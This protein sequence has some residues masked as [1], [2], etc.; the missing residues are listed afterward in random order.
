[1]KKIV[2]GYQ[3]S[4]DNSFEPVAVFDSLEEAENYYKNEGYV[5]KG[6]NLDFYLTLSKTDTYG[7]KMIIDLYS[8]DYIKEGEV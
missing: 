6:R 3:S 8:V 1:M 7:D 4:Y 5:A 2:A